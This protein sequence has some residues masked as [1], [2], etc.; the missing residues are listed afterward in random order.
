MKL[1]DK[2]QSLSSILR[3][4]LFNKRIPLA[5]R[6][7]VT[8]RCTLQCKYCNLWDSKKKELTT[9]EIFDI[10]KELSILG[11]KRLSISGGEPLLRTDIAEIIDCCW[12]HGIYPEMNSN[13]TILPQKIDTVKKT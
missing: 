11:T 1:Q 2:I 12:E 8:N 9:R 13:G 10:I 3:V 4:K 5:V 7:Q 6:L